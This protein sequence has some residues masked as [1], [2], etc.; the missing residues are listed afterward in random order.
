MCPSQNKRALFS[1]ALFQTQVFFYTNIG[2][3]SDPCKLLQDLFTAGKRESWCDVAP[4]FPKPLESP[5]RGCAGK[6]EAAEIFQRLFLRGMSGTSH[7][8]KEASFEEIEQ[9]LKTSWQV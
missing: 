4:I 3:E 9:E 8:Q 5:S 7:C 1:V 6:S 2:N